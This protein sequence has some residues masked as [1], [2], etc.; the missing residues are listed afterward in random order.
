[1]IK[2]SK[3]HKSRK[4]LIAKARQVVEKHPKVLFAYLFGGL[5]RKEPLPLS[6]V[7]VAVCIADGADL[8]EE[9]LLLLGDLMGELE[10]DEI[11]LV[12]LNTAPLP[13]KARILRSKEILLDRNPF[14]RH[15]FES[16]ALREYFDF[17]VKEEGILKRRYS[18]GR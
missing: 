14:F 9:K 10:T 17:A 13:L 18:L 11:D 15:S 12:I 16:L 1:M 2:F 3:V 4:K 8:A 6:D 7:D 5:A